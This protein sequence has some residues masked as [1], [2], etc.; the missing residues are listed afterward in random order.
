MK[1]AVIDDER[2]S[3]SELCF[4]ISNALPGASIQ[5][6]DSGKRAL[7]LAAEE[8]FDIVFVDIHLGDIPGT[9]LAQALKKL[10]PET[11]IIFAT[12][13]DEYAVRAFELDAADYL[14]KP[15]EQ[16]RVE[17]ALAKAQRRLDA[18]SAQDPSPCAGPAAGKLS[19]NCDKRVVVLDIKEILYLET[20][21]RSCLIH[22]KA[23]QYSTSQPLGFFEQKLSGQRF[24][25]IH[26]S[27]LINL[28]QVREVF[29]WGNS[30]FGLRMRG[31]EDTVLP[32]GREK[33]KR[34][35]QMLGW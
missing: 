28:D 12:A 30:S 13:Y 15:F 22:T 11:Q 14:M 25:R 10:T 29:P 4:L 17:Q 7:E 34:L 18:V 19:I 32:V 16:K 31:R 8:R 5:E 9:T 27:Y 3:R 24:F 23:K 26:K 2:P 1:I 20:D 6:A 35:R 21:S 33:T